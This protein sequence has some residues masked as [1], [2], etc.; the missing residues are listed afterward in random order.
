MSHPVEIGSLKVN[1]LIII[2][3]EPCKIVSMEKSKPGKHG[4][5]KV[6]VVAIGL[7]DGVKR[8]IVSPVD[9]TV[10]VPIVDKRVG[11]VVA[12]TDTVQLMDT[13]TYEVFEVPLPVEEDIRKKL[14]PGVQVEYW[15]VLN[16][17]KIV[18][19]KSE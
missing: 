9:A 7:F 14:E 4:A 15:Q 1:S 18:R 8:S 3:G 19:V 6:R 11:Q 12:V 16:R 2:D 13:E 17:R 10:E 5:A